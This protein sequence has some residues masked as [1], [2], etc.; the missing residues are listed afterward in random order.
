MKKYIL[1]LLLSVVLMFTIN[2]FATDEYM[3]SYAIIGERH[4]DFEIRQAGFEK[5]GAI[6]WKIALAEHVDRYI[7][8]ENNIVIAAGIVF[9]D[10]DPT[11]THNDIADYV[12]TN[13]DNGYIQKSVT[14]FNGNS[15]GICKKA[16]KIV[17]N[18]AYF[19]MTIY[20][21]Y[22]SELEC[23]VTQTNVFSINKKEE[24]F[25]YLCAHGDYAY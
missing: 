18:L 10:I 5:V 23:Y 1:I 20:N 9:H 2:S 12:E 25:L 17:G 19:P 14:C 22:D 13:V 21:T 11:L 7:W 8:V 6:T 16:M 24:Q 15:D 4:S 3:A